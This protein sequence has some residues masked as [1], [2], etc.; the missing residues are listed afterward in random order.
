MLKEIEDEKKAY[1]TRIALQE[2]LESISKLTIMILIIA[3]VIVICSCYT[4]PFRNTLWF[5]FAFI[6]VCLT[7]AMVCWLNIEMSMKEN[8]G[9]CVRAIICVNFALSVFSATFAGILALEIAK[10]I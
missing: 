2:C 6:F 7:V 4:L 1:I 10:K 5:F 8:L 9:Y 3:A